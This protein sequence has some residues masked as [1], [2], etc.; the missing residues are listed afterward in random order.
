[1]LAG[2]LEA[3]QERA[4]VRREPELR[5]DVLLV[6]HHGSKTSSSSELLAA[7]Q[8]AVGLVQAGYRS[9]FG[10]PAPPV[11]ARYQAAGIA[12]VASPACG[13]WRWQSED[14]PGLA[15]C[16]RERSPRYW[17]DTGWLPG[18]SAGPPPPGDTSPEDGGSFEPT[19]SLD[20]VS[21][22][23]GVVHDGA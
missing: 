13:A 23:L 18:G 9:R 12:I 10:H 7:V 3:E 14:P 19:A 8:P 1:V 20:S 22:H 17:R 4:L 11:L 15:V 21:S 16:E 5:A 6:P 2:D